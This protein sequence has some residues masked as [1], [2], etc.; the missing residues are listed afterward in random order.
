MKGIELS[1]IR[2]LFKQEIAS[3][4]VLRA[5]NDLFTAMHQHP[6]LEDQN[7]ANLGLDVQEVLLIWR[8]E[9][10]GSPLEFDAVV[11]CVVQ[12]EMKGDK[13]LQLRFH[14]FDVHKSIAVGFEV[15]SWT[16]A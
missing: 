10:R 13:R 2:E 1:L 15:V 4:G 12:V 9:P 3:H 11:V 5:F 7:A 16:I 8:P 6:L 14:V